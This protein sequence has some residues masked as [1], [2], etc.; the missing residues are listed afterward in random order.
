M[1]F[2]VGNGIADHPQWRDHHRQRLLVGRRAS[3]TTFMS[4]WQADGYELTTVTA[5][6]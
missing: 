1:S 4:A 3:I 6:S 5:K 2:F